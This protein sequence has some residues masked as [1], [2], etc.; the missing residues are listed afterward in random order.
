M[1]FIELNL[2]TLYKDLRFHIIVSS[3]GVRAKL[4]CRAL[5]TLPMI[6]YVG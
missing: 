6:A 5:K 2:I 4:F 1:K 3:S